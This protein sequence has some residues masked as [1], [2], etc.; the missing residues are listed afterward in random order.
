MRMYLMSH[1]TKV[2]NKKA[3]TAAVGGGESDSLSAV[4]TSSVA[5]KDATTGST[6]NET[7]EFQCERENCFKM[8]RTKANRRRHERTHDRT[9]ARKFKC[10][11]DNCEAEF[12]RREQLEN[13]KS[14]RAHVESAKVVLKCDFP[15]T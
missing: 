6:V 14:K 5:S 1:V 11:F 13:H 8:F 2:H 3:I 4:A 12:N 15:G 7:V 9:T 10:E